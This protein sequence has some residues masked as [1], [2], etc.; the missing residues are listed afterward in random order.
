MAGLKSFQ[1][2]CPRDAAV[3]DIKKLAMEQCNI[4]PEH[5]RLIYNSRQ[6]KDGDTLECYKSD[7]PIQAPCFDFSSLCAQ[8]P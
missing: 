3:R 7:A 5:M 8:A 1:L 4:E 2:E 6:L